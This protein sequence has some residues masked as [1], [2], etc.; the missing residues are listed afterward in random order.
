MTNDYRY[1]YEDPAVALERR[2]DDL[3]SRMA[4]E[5]KVA[6]VFHSE[7][8]IGDPEAGDHWGRPGPGELLRD[9]G[10][11]HFLTQGS[12]RDGREMAEWHN[13]LQRIALERPLRIP[14]TLSSDPR[15]S[16]TENVLT[17]SAAGAFSSWPEAL[18][19][20]AIGSS[21]TAQEFGDVVRREY[22]AAGIR[23]ALHPQVDLA[24]EP[25]WARMIQTFG[26]DADLTGRLAVA[27]VAG[28]QGPSVGHSSV[29]AMAKHFPGGGPQKDGLDPHFKDGREQVYPGGRFD[30]HLAPFV[31]LIEAGVA[32]MMPYYGM[33]VGTEWEEV[34]FAYNKGIITG[35]LRE[36]LGFD[37]VVCTD[38]GVITG[39]GDHFPARAWGVEHLSREERAAQLIRSGVDQ[40]GGERDVEVLLNAIK[41]G[42]V[43]EAQLDQPARRLLREKFRLG[44]FDGARMVDPEEALKIIGS[45]G[46][47]AL[48]RR[49]QQQSMV[50]LQ[51]NDN[52]DGMPLLPLPRGIR[53][54]VEGMD[55]GA[56]AG[57]ASV[58]ADPGEADAAIIRTSS[59]DYADPAL[60]FLGSMHKGSLE[61]RTV[62]QEHVQAVAAL[63]PTVLDIYLDR[64]A[65]LTGLLT[66]SAVFGS[67]GTDDVP[68]VE[69][70]F[71][72]AQPAGSLPFDLPRS[73]AAVEASR[74]D[75]PFDTENPLFRFGH[76]LR[77][78]QARIAQVAADHS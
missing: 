14:V 52:K 53:V 26:E 44:L 75:V 69:V 64:P 62:D 41:S 54:Y 45:T 58:V 1:P 20:A 76:G 9:R 17:S 12:P 67:F 66:A 39:M 27:Y 42:S 15:H 32:Q 71:G 60:H 30:Y 38:F 29:A 49:A 59:P 36:Q 63:V 50:L 19:I 70:L 65:V 4:L 22:L 47:R 68:F 28:L 31:D 2:V 55:A 7:V 25:R 72:A 34:G 11:T 33:P 6:L 61:F 43:S 10:I 5:D 21:T 3:L 73:M 48:G 24:T 40:F 16:V 51:N 37:G 8:S 13:Q 56:F 78:G 35:L 18:G 74:T 46:N 23:V 77:Y 57:F